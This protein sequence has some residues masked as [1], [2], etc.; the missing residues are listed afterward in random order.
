MSLE[1]PKKPLS[2]LIWFCLTNKFVVLLLALLVIVLGLRSAP[3]DWSLGGMT[4]DPVPVDAI[5]D[6][7]ENQQIIFTE[8]AGRSPQDVEDQVGYPL[9]VSLLGIPGVKT[10]RSYSMFGFSSIYI[11]FEEDIEF[12]WSRSRIL[13]KLNSLSSGTLPEGVKPT[14]G[15]DA[16]GLGQVYWYTIEG[17]DEKGKPA[18]GWDL[19]ELRSTQDWYVRYLLQSTKGVSE[20]ASIGGFV[21]EYQIDV[22]PD[23]MR[24]FGVSLTEVYSAV[25][26]ANL[27]VGARSIEVNQVEYLVRGLGFVKSVADLE[28]TVVKVNDN[29]PVYI[30]NIAK[31]KLGPALRRGALD[32]GGVEAVGGVV[33]ARYGENPMATITAVKEKIKKELAPGMPEKVYIDWA[34]ATHDEVV[35]GFGQIQGQNGGTGLVTVDSSEE[36]LLGFYKSLPEDE[37][38]EWLRYSK[39]TIVPFYDRSGLIRETLGTLKTAIS[40]EILVTIIVIL[41]MVRHLASSILISSL[42]PMAVLMTFIA[43]RQFGVDANI[44]ALSGIAI[45]IGT[46]VDMGIVVC[47]NILQKLKGPKGMGGSKPSALQLIH[48]ATSEVGGA[49]LTAVA[50][51]I[52][53][54]LPVF[55]ME[56]PEG[57]LFKPLAFTKT[58]ALLSAVVVAL[59]LI[60]ALFHIYTLV[61]SKVGPKRSK[62]TSSKFHFGWVFDSVAVISVA[63]I[64]SNSWL[65]MGPERGGFI[66]FVSVL[67]MIGSVLGTLL[68]FQRSYRSIL[69]WALDHKGVFLSLPIGL[70]VM[71]MTIWLG[72]DRVFAWLPNVIRTAGPVVSV[73]HAFPGLGKEFMPALD[74]GSFLF[75]PS[76]MAHASIGEARDVLSKQDL[77]IESVPEVAL[78][79]G[80][81]GR[82]ESSLD[83]A[84]ISMYET[85]VN[86]HSE[87]LVDEDGKRL[88]FQFDATEN[89]LFRNEL[90]EP[91]NAPDGLPYQVHGK[92]LR[93]QDDRL[94]PDSGGAPF[95]L[96]RP[97]LDT[98]LNEKR[99]AWG[100]VQSPDDIWD[101]LSRVS[102]IPGTTRAP[103][104]QPIETRLIMLQ[105]GMR[106]PMG[107]KVK[108][109]DL[110]SI[111]KTGLALEQLVK[112]VSGVL[113]ET[114]IADRIVGKPY[115]EIEI[116]REAIAR[117]GLHI[118][119]VQDVIQGA[120]GGMTLTHTVEGRERYP[121]RVRYQRELRDSIESLDSI[122]V[123]APDGTQVPLTQLAEIRYTRGPQSIKSEDTFLMGYV[124]FDKNPKLAEVDVV[125]TVQRYLDQARDDGRLTIPEGVSYSFSGNFENQVRAT[126]K[127]MLV[128]PMAL[129]AIM[130][131]LYLQFRSAITAMLVFSGVLVAWSGGFILL[132]M[133][134]QDWFLNGALFGSSL[135][136]TFN[137]HT[138]NLSVAVWVGF[139]ALF[140][141]ATDDG[142][143]MATYLKQ[144]FEKE[145]F[146]DKKAIRLA[147]IEGALRRVRPCLMTSATTILAL[148]PILS[149]SGRGAD[150]MI[151][152]AIPTFGGMLVVMVSMFVVPVLYCLVTEVQV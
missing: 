76:T 58:F 21:Q 74:E 122:I 124:T 9:T 67:L 44:V 35:A 43:M 126:E 114:V 100:G 145:S 34:K 42:L 84:P 64:L 24:A 91:I 141:I 69:T 113:P 48:E 10:V 129:T 57:K 2:A 1:Q 108:G 8:W 71:G 79:V 31:V 51:T 25:K 148:L 27:D 85:V 139:L 66:N 140:G 82:V 28:N 40:E 61:V 134:G 4:R 3:F 22:N 46:M 102:L 133:Y 14:L 45:A 111:E 120:I 119:H 146:K 52:L 39:L 128:V 18:G 109:P 110:A 41:V 97:S 137:V 112:E 149:S 88:R 101:E 7:G 90:G 20:V 105:T 93:D 26:M 143:I 135:R 5:P 104:L 59:A 125:E 53:S 96:W 56:G 116:N 138:I 50:T 152:M 38:P 78:V 12:Y 60:P 136:D 37:R 36:E 54:F 49:V 83:P 150:V 121:V 70:V 98:G 86:Y 13:E 147:T 47:E 117:Y 63:W 68:L 32:K 77:A 87:F 103:K 16:T 33:V 62:K 142:V 127:L 19:H 95:R 107:I 6:I 30:R 99:S 80:K 75:M 15:P 131:V 17:R 132:W 73:A 123:P 11:I 92:Y 23:T 55:A 72:F 144:R 65:P 94:I 115:L 81:L 130:L 151:P 106:A 89:D 118:K 29:V